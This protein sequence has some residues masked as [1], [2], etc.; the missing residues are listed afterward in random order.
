M[1]IFENAKFITC[2]A[3]NHVYNAMAV[4]AK[5][6]ILWMGE[7]V[8]DSCKD[9]PHVDLKGAVVVPAFGD[10]HLHFESFAM[11]ENTF[12]ISE[13]LSFDEIKAIIAAYGVAHPQ[14]KILLGFGACG[15]LVQEGRLP[16]RKDL[17]KWSTR[18]LFIVK[19]DGHA[20]VCNSAMMA[21][22]S[23]EV[24]SDPGC[25]RDSG[26]LYQDAF[27]K[28]TNEV[29]AKVSPLN[30]IKGLSKGAAALTRAGIGLIHTVEGV[31]YANDLDVDMI[32]MLKT[33]LPQ[34]IRIFF[35]TMDVEKVTKRKMKRIGGCFELALDGCFGSEDAAL[36]EPYANDPENSGLLNYTQEQVNAFAIEANRLGLQIT[37][38][39]IGDAAVEQCITAYEAALADTP[40][41]DHRHIMI[42]CCLVSQEQL[43]RIAKLGLCLAV[44]AP[45]I[46]W[47]QE[48]DAYLRSILGDERT[49]ILN[50]LRWMWD[51]GIVIA[52]GSDAPCTVPDPI[53][54]MH[55]AVNHPN[56]DLRLTPQEALKM[57]TYNAAY[58]SFD[59]KERGSLE[60]GKRADFTLLSD[61]PLTVAPEKIGDIKVEALYLK[62]KKVSP[63]AKNALAVVLGAL[64]GADKR[65]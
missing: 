24:K 27:Y 22:L 15:H 21:I 23:D 51:R 64:G 36:I 57:R 37:M 3:E 33:G 49:D 12:N 59:E 42:H 58:L 44:Q 8:P 26:W 62:G 31:G 52:D 32:R 30:I 61:D 2:D 13:A 5:G 43:D 16:G 4:D 63:K 55:L 19:Y 25:D 10:T 9:M 20:A 45:F 60:V 41:E 28:G 29:T 48:P 39:A 47:K 65:G 50:P 53:R 46:D 17:D 11:F 7:D 6:R 54:G 14:E 40:R 56:P 38:H 1:P 35:Q 18:P 34:T